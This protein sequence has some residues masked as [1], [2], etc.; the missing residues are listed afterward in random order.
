MEN[1]THST[2]TCPVCGFRKTEK[3]PVDTCQYFYECE[4]CSTEIKPL[5]GDCC[6]YCSYGTEKCSSMQNQVDL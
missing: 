2:I 1:K 4:N 5:K 6:V 3:M